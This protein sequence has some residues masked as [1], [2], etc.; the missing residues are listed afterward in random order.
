MRKAETLQS[1]TLSQ[2]DNNLSARFSYNKLLKHISKKLDLDS[3]AC[4]WAQSYTKVLLRNVI[5][6]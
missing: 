6:V 5:T 2:L 4:K 3:D 1:E